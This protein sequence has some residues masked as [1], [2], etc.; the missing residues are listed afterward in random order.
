MVNS[1]AQRPGDRRLRNRHPD[2][3]CTQESAHE[4]DVSSPGE[5]F[6]TCGRRCHAFR[7]YSACRKPVSLPR[8]MALW[9]IRISTPTTANAMLN[10]AVACRP[11]IVA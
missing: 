8:V 7:F 6:R 2:A 10:T 11:A 4:A 9:T 1:N 5:C 3:R